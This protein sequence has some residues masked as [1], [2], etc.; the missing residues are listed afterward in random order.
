MVHIDTTG[1]KGLKKQG[2]RVVDW[3]HLAQGKDKLMAVVIA[4][5]NLRNW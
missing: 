1:I 4:A 5:M 2:V 3:R